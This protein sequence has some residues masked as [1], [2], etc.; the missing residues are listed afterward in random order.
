ML[1]GVAAVLFDEFHERS[2]D[3]DL[4]L[5]LGRDVQQGLRED[6]RLVAMSATIDGVR[7]ANL[8][9]TRQ[10][11]PQRAARIRSRPVTGR[12]AR[13]IEPQ[14]ADAIVR[15]M[16]ADKGSYPAFLPGTA[17]IRRTKSLLDAFVSMPI[18]P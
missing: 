17:E 9:A 8:L 5:A 14:M 7:V 2:L 16:R 15:A 10:S 11:L 4:G 12:D 1:D 13:P 6:L 18:R 3:A